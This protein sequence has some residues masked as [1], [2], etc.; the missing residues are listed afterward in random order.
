MSGR[1]FL[2]FSKKKD[3]HC[4]S[5]HSDTVHTNTLF[6]FPSQKPSCLVPVHHM[7]HCWLEQK[8]KFHCRAN[9]CFNS[10]YLYVNIELSIFTD[11]RSI[12]LQG[13]LE[14]KTVFISFWTLKL[15]FMNVLPKCTLAPLVV[16]NKTRSL[17]QRRKYWGIF[18]Y[19]HSVFEITARL[20]CLLMH[21]T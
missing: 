1:C 2:S 9:C 8:I 4:G 19:L 13:D 10:I 17:Y 7:Q 21:K 6:C 18:L 14:T 3:F 5:C 15:I 12:T 16:C 20:L 11:N